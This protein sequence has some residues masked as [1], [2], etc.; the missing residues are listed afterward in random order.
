MLSQR[1]MLSAIK[2][3]PFFL[4]KTHVGEN[5]EIITAIVIHT[6]QSFWYHYNDLSSL[7]N[8][9]FLYFLTTV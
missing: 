1:K 3:S 9:Q 7:Q 4:L 6:L 8:K 5:I 2:P